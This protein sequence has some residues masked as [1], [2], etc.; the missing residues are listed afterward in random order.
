MSE[1]STVGPAL[2]DSRPGGSGPGRLPL[3][4]RRPLW[5][6]AAL[7][8]V[9]WCAAI[10]VLL[11]NDQRL[12]Q[13][14]RLYLGSGVT[15]NLTATL[16]TQL[17]KLHTLTLLVLLVCLLDRRVRWTLLANAAWV[18]GAQAAAADLLK[19]VFGRLRPDVSAEATVFFGPT[20]AGGEFGFPSGHATAACALAAVFCAYY[21]RWRYLLLL[22]AAAV[23]LS[24][25]HQGRHFFSDTL[26]GAVLGWYLA[27]GVL[28]WLRCR[29]HRRCGTT[30]EQGERR[31]DGGE[32]RAA[33]G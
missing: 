26:A 27:Q 7:T 30:G 16:L 29:R 28:A 8:A 32:E 14:W 3:W 19:H 12:Q 17:I 33:A 5:L 25:V 21:P 24:R 1:A 31:R 10:A 18:M 11:V 13:S 2:A 22:G 4:C 15:I 9:L 20:V 6:T 23:C